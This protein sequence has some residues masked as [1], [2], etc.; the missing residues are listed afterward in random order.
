[1]EPW[2]LH[3]GEV[4]KLFRSMLALW[5]LGAC[6]GQDQR[7]APQQR[8]CTLI[9]RSVPRGVTRDEAGNPVSPTR[10]VRRDHGEEWECS[11]YPD[12]YSCQERSGGSVEI[13]VYVAGRSW[14]KRVQIATDGCHELDTQLDLVLDGLRSC[15][16]ATA[17]EGSVPEDYGEA[18]VSLERKATSPAQWNMP[19]NCP[20]EQDRYRCPALGLY[21]TAEYEL[22]LNGEVKTTLRIE[23]RDCKVETQRYD[24]E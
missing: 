23:A 11:L 13:K 9:E 3:S 4:S 20:V 15:E 6:G 10:V 21:D 2:G 16:P 18:D 14:T 19:V 12:G 24:L 22:R 8:E 17:V 7:P 1:M 5:W